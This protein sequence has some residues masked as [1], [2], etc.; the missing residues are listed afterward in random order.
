MAYESDESG[1]REVYVRPFPDVEGGQWQVS[2][3]GGIA[4]LWSHGGSELYFVLEGDMMV[5]T[6]EVE[7]TFSVTGVE[8]LFEL[9][10]GALIGSGTGSYDVTL[11]DQRFVMALDLQTQ[12][13]SGETP[14]MVLVQNF[15][16]ELKARVPN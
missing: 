6:I 1:R 12:A 15:F 9:P 7:P 14:D 13:A 11:D 4:P 16:E 5:A 3:A 10:S 2:T 8:E